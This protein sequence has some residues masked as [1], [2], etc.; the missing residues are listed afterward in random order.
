MTVES[1]DLIRHAR[2]LFPEF[3]RLGNRE[4]RSGRW[5]L[6]APALVS[7]VRSA[8]RALMLGWCTFLALTPSSVRLPY[9]ARLLVI[10]RKTLPSFYMFVVAIW[11]LVCYVGLGIGY[12]VVALL[13]DGL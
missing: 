10:R 8:R 2:C 1:A 5:P 13:V 12:L 9:D 3:V 7:L 6:A 4:S 11:I